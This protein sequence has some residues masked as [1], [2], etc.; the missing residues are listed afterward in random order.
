MSFVI[1]QKNTRSPLNKNPKVFRGM[2][3]RIL[4][5]YE[6]NKLDNFTNF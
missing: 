3:T 5:F 6:S 4:C 2:E 1:L